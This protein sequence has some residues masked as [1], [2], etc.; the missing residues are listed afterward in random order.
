LRV[1][2]P[3]DIRSMFGEPDITSELTR[4]RSLEYRPF[5]DNRDVN[6]SLMFAGY[7][8]VFDIETNLLSAVSMNFADF[9]Q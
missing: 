7:T 5:F 6:R 9:A 4:T 8:F 3:A 1:T 2:T